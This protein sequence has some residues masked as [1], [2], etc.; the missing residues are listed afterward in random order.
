MHNSGVSGLLLTCGECDAV[1]YLDGR[2]L[3]MC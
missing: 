3:G 1:A 2:E